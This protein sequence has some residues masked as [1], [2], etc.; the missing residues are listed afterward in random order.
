MLENNNLE[1]IEKDSLSKSPNE[2]DNEVEEKET[3][4][5]YND[6]I[7]ITSVFKS[8]LETVYF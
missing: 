6:C 1:L 3:F 7:N 5:D 8:D 2:K 4:I